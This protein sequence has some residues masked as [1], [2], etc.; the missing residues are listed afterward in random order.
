M[1][2]AHPS[3]EVLVLGGGLSGLMA[4]WQLRRHG[5]PVRVWEASPAA[6]G[7]AQTLPW[8]GPK[9]E[10]GWL[11]RGPQALQI[12]PGSALERLGQ[13]LGLVYLPK[14]PKGPRWIGKGGQRH[15]S[16]LLRFPGLR[17]GERL[18][19]LGEPFI[20]AQPPERAGEETLAAFMARRLGR[21]FAREALPAF[22]AGVL[23]AP[24]ERLGLEAMPQLRELESRG[25]L[26]WG[27]LRHPPQ[28]SRHLAGGT[29]ALAQA[30]RMAL[31]AVETG[32]TARRLEVRPDG[33][34]QVWDGAVTQETP[35]VVLA[36]P[37]PRAASLLRDL[38]PQAA[39]LIAG[40]PQLDLQ[41][42][43]SR[44]P[45]VPHWTRGFT[46]LLHPPE[47]RGLLGVVALAAEDP[48]SVPGLLQ[49]RT[50][51]GGAYPVASDLEDAPGLWSELRRWLPELQDPLQ[52]RR[53]DSPG[54]FPLLEP[55]H[56]GRVA[57]ILEALPPG[58]HWLGASRFGPGIPNLAEGIE[59]WASVGMAL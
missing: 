2:P 13:A 52:T 28:R 19:L 9:G 42:W 57:S 53:E 47:G 40:I 29:G 49:L 1:S 51:L 39:C 15:P 10:P 31:G 54:A 58:L 38:A 48:R 36:L 18:R 8:P 17:L 33:G 37:A 56:A 4:A 59:R 6:G 55:G 23:A 7:W 50:Y 34:W 14:A 44:H 32:R 16:D 25:G 11:E 22:V 43:H 3:P 21:G 30:L 46:L 5:Y 26:L 24:P 12:Q 45:P 41:V 27:G 35:S 20:P